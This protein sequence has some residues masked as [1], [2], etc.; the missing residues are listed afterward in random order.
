MLQPFA[1]PPTQVAANQQ[2]SVDA[3]TLA[4]RQISKINV[5]LSQKQKQEFRVNTGKDSRS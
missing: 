5:V 1:R 3:N 2:Y 4:S